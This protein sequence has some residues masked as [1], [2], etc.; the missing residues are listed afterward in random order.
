MGA[1]SG[2]ESN[3]VAT[4]GRFA[5]ESVWRQCRR[6]ARRAGAAG[7][8]RDHREPTE[9]A[10]PLPASLEAILKLDSRDLERVI[11][12]RLEC[13]DLRSAERFLLAVEGLSE[14]RSDLSLHAGR[15]AV[16]VVLSLPA[17]KRWARRAGDLLARALILLA[18][19]A[20]SSRLPE[21]AE[22]CL[23]LALR[24]SRWGNRERPVRA[25]AL[26]MLAR[27]RARRHRFSC[28]HRVLMRLARIHAAAGEALLLGKALLTMHNNSLVWGHREHA[29]WAA[30]EALQVLSLDR[31]PVEF[32]TAAVSFAWVALEL[33]LTDEARACL[34]DLVQL[35]AMKLPR[36]VDLRLRW[37]EAWV[38]RLDK[39]YRQAEAKLRPL[40]RAYLEAG[41]EL[42][43]AIVG[44]EL[45]MLLVETGRFRQVP[46]ELGKV[47]PMFRRQN[48]T[49]GVFAALALT[50]R[51][52][53]LSSHEP[54]LLEQFRS[55]LA[56]LRRRTV[57][58]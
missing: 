4:P 45:A 30:R 1:S 10:D 33:E 3:A 48:W 41:K 5:I 51:A 56:Q 16:L 43:A 46:D 55:L 34:P 14:P 13:S 22:T 27:L 57:T 18:K 42:P 23:H 17:P 25:Q 50:Q 54:E 49:R 37:V 26:R 24:A 58:G 19:G 35:R 6:A 28:A 2:H 7:H 38:L 11:P 47:I 53:L 9:P 44:L 12:T 40:Q 52:A 39:K 8:L 29:L 21:L 15:V 36:A 31:Y 32:A 20:R